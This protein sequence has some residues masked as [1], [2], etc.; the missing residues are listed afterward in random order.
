MVGLIVVL[1]VVFLR[2]GFRPPLKPLLCFITM[3][4]IICVPLCSFTDEIEDPYA[5]RNIVILSSAELAQRVI[6]QLE[7]GGTEADSESVQLSALCFPTLKETDYSKGGF[8]CK[9]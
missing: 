5:N 8:Y 7:L 6:N 9:Q 2:S 3:F 1:F 4:L